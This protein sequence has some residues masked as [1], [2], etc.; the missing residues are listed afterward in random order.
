MQA[1]L[2]ELLSAVFED[3]MQ[4]FLF[5]RGQQVLQEAFNLGWS[6]ALRM[7]SVCVCVISHL[8]DKAA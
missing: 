8:C 4:D 6:F 3:W 1:Y 5:P 7:V 2:A